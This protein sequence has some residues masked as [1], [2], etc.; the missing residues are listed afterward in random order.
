M[1]EICCT[2]APSN[3]IKRDNKMLNQLKTKHYDT[4]YF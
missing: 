3:K 2:F 1:S 4:S